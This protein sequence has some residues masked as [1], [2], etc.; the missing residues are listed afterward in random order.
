MNDAKKKKKIRKEWEIKDLSK[1]E[2]KEM[3]FVEKEKRRIR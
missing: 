2:E 3:I 1:K